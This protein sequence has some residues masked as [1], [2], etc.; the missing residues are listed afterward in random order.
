M[1][2][3]W[4]SYVILLAFK[5]NNVCV[6]WFYFAVRRR[7][8]CVDSI[9]FVF[10]HIVFEE[11]FAGNAQRLRFGNGECRRLVEHRLNVKKT[12]AG[13]AFLRE[14]EGGISRLTKCVKWLYTLRLNIWNS[15]SKPRDL[16]VKRVFGRYWR[17]HE[18]G[19]VSKR[20]QIHFGIGENMYVCMYLL[21][22]ESMTG[23]VRCRTF[24]MGF[25]LHT[26]H[27]RPSTCCAITL[28]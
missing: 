3:V 11:L 15:K 25:N 26:V 1:C 2:K 6:Y 20:G 28:L 16:R 19:S 21:R 5:H 17:A 14:G 4:R 22:G 8:V 24:S 23:T 18:L 10:F 13:S 27:M 12:Y 7:S 9:K